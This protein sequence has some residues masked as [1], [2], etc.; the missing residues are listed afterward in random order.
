MKPARPIFIAVLSLLPFQKTFNQVTI[1]SG[2]EKG[3]YYRFVEDIAGIMSK[4]DM[5]VTNKSTEG[6][7]HN[8]KVLVNPSSNDKFALIQA[9]YLNQMIAEDKL[10]NTNKTGSLK[11][12]LEMA[13][14]EIHIIVR[15]S[16]GIVKMQDLEKKKIG[17][18]K[19]DQGS[20]ATANLITKRSNIGWYTYRVG[21][22]EMLKKLRE[23][24]LDAGLVVG[25]APMNMLEIDPQVMPDGISL[26]ELSDYNGWAKYYENDTIYKGEYKWLEKDVPTFGVRTLLIVNESKLTASDKAAVSA[27]QKGIA[28]NLDYL[29]KQGHAKWKSVMTPDEPELT[30]EKPAQ[31]K[32]QAPAPPVTTGKDAIVYRV[33]ICSRQYNKPEQVTISGQNY[34][35]YVYT[36]KGAY[37]YTVGEFK[38]VSEATALQKACRQAGYPEAF[39]AAFRNNDRSTDP[40][41]FR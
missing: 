3:S 20:F 40:A 33:Q 6:S 38:T 41:L 8:F 36:Y 9:D 10:N 14:E 26:V 17:I 5:P 39:V 11:V 4:A 16:S 1:L 7:A 35:T 13:T 28:E 29:K 27:L 34:T 32:S 25:S 30:A 2:P 37:R 12:V 23:G 22:E 21:F 18:G 24:S 19:E 15:K 31:V